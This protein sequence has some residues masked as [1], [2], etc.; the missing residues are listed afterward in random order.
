MAEQSITKILPFFL[1]L[2]TPKVLDILVHHYSGLRKPEQT[3]EQFRKTLRER[4][5][6]RA[7]PDEKL[8]LSEDLELHYLGQ[9]GGHNT[10]HQWRVLYSER[11][12]GII[13]KIVDGT[14]I[15]NSPRAANSNEW[16]GTVFRSG[17]E[18]RIAE[19]LYRSDTLFFVNCMGRVSE[20]G[21]PV[22][23]GQSNGRLEVDFLVFIK[24]KAMILEVD[25][26]HHKEVP[27]TSRD[28]VRDRLMLREGIPTARFT[29]TECLEK[30]EQ[31]VQEF[32]IMFGT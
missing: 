2:L 17:A 9:P 19:A 27:Q 23:A 22:S 20:K 8:Q 26:P 31:V 28:Y 1:D 11:I 21:S 3:K 4:L 15:V 30:P 24:G 14:A 5:A 6:N 32:L 25:G 13:D 10:Y 7:K 29:H 12:K 16:G 18:K